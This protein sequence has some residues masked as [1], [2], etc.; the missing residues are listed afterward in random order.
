MRRPPKDLPRR[1]CWY[2]SR[3]SG[4]TTRQLWTWARSCR[5]PGYSPTEFDA[6]LYAI[7]GIGAQCTAGVWYLRDHYVPPP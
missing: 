2:L 1:L 3:H 5:R 4:V 6:A 7:R